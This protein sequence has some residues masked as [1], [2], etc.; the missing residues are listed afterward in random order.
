MA[1][2]ALEHVNLTVSDPDRTAWMMER[3]FDWHERWR[4]VTVGRGF[5]VH[6]GNEMSYLALHVPA[7]APLDGRPAVPGR[8]LNHVGILVEQLDEVERRALALGLKPY[9]HA[10]YAPGRRFYFKDGDGIEYEVVSYA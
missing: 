5:T 4:G 1:H 6:V 3:L 7:A 9:G 2:A 10:D 8:P